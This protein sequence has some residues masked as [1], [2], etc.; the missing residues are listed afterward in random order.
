MAYYKVRIEVWCDWNP[1]ESDLE[2]IAQNIS[3][4]Q[5][6][7]IKRE[8]RSSRNTANIDVF[9]ES[10]DEVVSLRQR[11]AAFEE[12]ARAPRWN[13]VIANIRG[14]NKT[15]SLRHFA[16]PHQAGAMRQEKISKRSRSGAAMNFLKHRSFVCSH[17]CP[18]GLLICDHL[19]NEVLHPDGQRG[20]A[21]PQI[22]ADRGS[23]SRVREGFAEMVN[24]SARRP[25]SALLWHPVSAATA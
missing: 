3:A 23:M 8:T 25:G 17:R 10:P 5:A 24:N 6:I 15:R 1:A 13:P 16:P 14:S 22:V 19:A 7:C 9:R 18:A 21:G 20:Q 2:E 4:G 11:C 12:K